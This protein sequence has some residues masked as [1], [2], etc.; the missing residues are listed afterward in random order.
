MRSEV[1][2]QLTQVELATTDVEGVG[3]DEEMRNVAVWA[4]SNF[5]D[6]LRGTVA[7]DGCSRRFFGGARSD[8]SVNRA[9][10]QGRPCSLGS[11]RCD[12]DL[13]AC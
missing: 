5:L 12:A 2:Q 13:K 6:Q 10:W 4:M 9:E 7:E 1:V 8:N 11:D 3:E